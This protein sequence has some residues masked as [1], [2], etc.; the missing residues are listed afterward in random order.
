MLL[1]DGNHLSPSL[2]YRSCPSNKITPRQLKFQFTL[3]K[4]GVV[5]VVGD[6][7]IDGVDI[8]GIVG[9][10]FSWRRAYHWCK[11]SFS[12]REFRIWV[13]TWV[14]RRERLSLNFNWC[15]AIWLVGLEEDMWF[16]SVVVLRSMCWTCDSSP[17]T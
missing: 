8:E 6:N 2:S 13:T 5:T 4:G 1:W 16:P 9:E 3:S 12:G 14:D 7:D 10:F 15:G 17:T 11:W